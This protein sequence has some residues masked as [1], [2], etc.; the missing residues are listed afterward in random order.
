VTR[1]CP[2]GEQGFTLLEVM[3]ATSVL[4]IVMAAIGPVFY[5]A[6]RLTG[7]TDQR[8]QA[9]NLAGAAT[10]Q[11]RS[12][13]YSEVGFYTTSTQCNNNNETSVTLPSPG[14]LDAL[15][16]STTVGQTLYTMVRCVYW[17]A[18][19]MPGT[20]QAYKQTLVKVSWPA[21]GGVLAVSQTS[22]LYPGTSVSPVPSTTT[23]TL[24]Q[25]QLLPPTCSASTDSGQPTNTID[26]SLVE[27]PGGIEPSY[28]LVYYTSSQPSGNITAG[29]NPYTTVQSPGTTTHLD[30]GAGTK[31][32]IQ[33]SAVGPDG[34]MSGPANTCSAT[35]T[36]PPGTATT[37]TSTTNSSAATATALSL[38]LGAATVP[39]VVTPTSA[40]NSGSGSNNPQSSQPLPSIPGADSFI[41][42]SGTAQVAEANTDGSSYACAGVLSSGN[43]LSGG[44]WTG[45]CSTSGTGTGGI[46][47]NLTGLP[48]VGSAISSVVGGLTLNLSGA[49][50]WASGN[51]GGTSLTGSASLSG[52]TVKVTTVGGLVTRTLPLNLPSTLT[53]STD[54]VK[55]ITT[56]I[57]SSPA[58]AAL[59]TP[60]QAAL[61]PVLSL[62]GDYQ[63]TNNGVLTVSALHISE[64][65]GAGTG[66]LARTTVGPNTS[67]TT[68]TTTYT[69]PPCA[70]YSLVVYPTT[71]RGGSGGVA[72]TS[73][74]T[75]ADESSFQLSVNVG[76]GCS[77]IEVG[78]APTDCVP[79]A[80][81][82][83][84]S[85]ATLS[86]NG[87]TL[88]GSAGDSSTVWNVG[89]TTFTVFAGSTPAPSSPVE[90]Q[91]V[92][93]CTEQG[94][95]GEC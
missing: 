8:S 28:Y 76:T 10:E 39:Y 26:L 47:I 35:T 38:S 92:M 34:T 63:N 42:A 70:I 32:W 56:A 62:T 89:T 7:I 60:L 50:S 82:C 16:G 37:T 20:N 51:T 87:G 75:L 79:G 59:A 84:T 29:S 17:S 3:I 53:T 88:Y 72:L 83:N 64:L 90:T 73:S 77:N 22:A 95:T 55:A 41:T 9:T 1:G 57:G 80:T 2:G 23:T 74:G 85:F 54:V 67:N 6:M 66:D 45:P 5:G 40:T 52:A 94:T 25:T 12:L 48:G 11:M 18:S 91:Q 27:P 33:A 61:A 36:S 86:G 68:I 31:Y 81:G 13:P 15:P 30:V 71:G 4:A 78:Y 46:S 21:P 65:N 43:T 93:L 24:P 14:P 69:P 49:T 58:V 44:S 19:S